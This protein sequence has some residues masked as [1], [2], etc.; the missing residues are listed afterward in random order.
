MYIVCYGDI[1]GYHE[2]EFTHYGQAQEFVTNN[3]DECNG[4]SIECIDDPDDDS[5][6]VSR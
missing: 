6:Y 4:M 2:Q 1:N 3:Q 5:Y